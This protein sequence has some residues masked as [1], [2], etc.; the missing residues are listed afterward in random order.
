VEGTNWT[1]W[2]TVALEEVDSTSSEARRR[3]ASRALP[4]PTLIRAERQNAG[5]GRGANLWWSDSGSLTFSLVFPPRH[6]GLQNRQLPRVAIA[7]AVG[8]IEAVEQLGVVPPGTLGIRWPNDLESIDGKKLGGIL[9]EAIRDPDGADFLV[10]GIGLNIATDLNG[11]PPAIQEMATT[12]ER[13]GGV[14]V[15]VEWLL[16]TML[17]CID[18]VMV[19]LAAEA[20]ALSESWQ[21]RDLLLGKRATVLIGER[22]L[23]GEG[24]GIDAEGRL[25]LALDDGTLEAVVAGRVLR[26]SS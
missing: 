14:P 19:S 3:V 22:T 20:P 6:Y 24:R 11:A 4:R 23:V 7:A 12:V 13:L 21:A 15:D 5:R 18:S 10:V 26:Q 8:V 2:E 9:P 25:W 17:R 1:A 16:G